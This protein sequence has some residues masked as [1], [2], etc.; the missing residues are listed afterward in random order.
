M[1]IAPITSTS[2]TDPNGIGTAAYMV[3]AIKLEHTTSGVYHNPSQ[4]VFWNAGGTDSDGTTT[5][6]LPAPDSNA[7]TIAASA[8]PAGTPFSDT[9]VAVQ[10]SVTDNIGATGAQF[11]I[12]GSKL[13]GELS[14]APYAV[15]L[16]TLTAQ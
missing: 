14:S 15:T 1:T 6:P 3:R 13:G 16:N 11:K 4:G 12:E 9:S 7:P 5:P 8:P 2:F 10:A